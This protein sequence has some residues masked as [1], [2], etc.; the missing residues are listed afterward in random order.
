MGS[1]KKRKGEAAQRAHDAFG[2]GREMVNSHPL[3]Q[4]LAYEVRFERFVSAQQVAKDGW[5]VVTQTGCV[6]C[7]PE[8]LAS[9][10]E[11]A[12]ALATG[13]LHHA[14]G[15][16]REHEDPQLWQLACEL[17][18][19][20]FLHDL[21]FGR[22]PFGS[23]P[24]A[25]AG[26]DADALVRQLQ[27][28]PDLARSL[29]RAMPPLSGDRPG[30]IL[31]GVAKDWQGTPV[32]FAKLFALGLR[33]AVAGAVEVAGGLRKSL[34][35]PGHKRSVYERA[36]DWFVSG[37]PLLGALARH[38]EIVDDP[39]V[40]RRLD[41]SVAAVDE[42]EERIYVN[43]GAGLDF[44][45]CI[46][47]IAHELLHVG[48]RHLDRR[49]GRDAFLWNVACDFV[50][51]AWLL[52]MR[53]GSP[54]S[55]GM[56]H[57]AKLAGMSAEEV[58]DRVVKDLRLQRRL[59][60]LRGRGLGDMMEHD[61]RVPACGSWTDL[62]ALYRSYLSRGLDLHTAQGRG[63]LPAGLVEEIRALLQPPVPW[64][65]RLAH[66][67]EEWFPSIVPKRTYAR[68]SRRQAS[69]PD[70]PRPSYHIPDEM[71][72]G[73]TFGVVLDTSG[74]MNRRQLGMALGAI[75][76]Y[77]DRHDVR[78]ARVVFCD[79]HPYDA[80]YLLPE[81]IAG[82]VRVRG[83]GGTILQPGVDLL[84]AAEDFPDDGPIL[85]ITDGDCDVLRIRREHAFLLPKGRRLPFGTKA[86]V[87]EFA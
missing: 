10:E 74:S 81:Q 42:L 16:I 86:P 36:R 70:I 61:G 38:F 65:V 1:R 73:R 28:S 2:R 52:E 3:F 34:G 5:I 84:E 11:W 69:T 48:L 49:Q 45:Q 32:D 60:T 33:S 43:R 87:F 76:S 44:D 26:R 35:S 85:L 55:I 19:A 77:A 47:V 80:G 40:C 79:A 22:S 58:Y 9:A 18:A 4:P 39:E 83:R 13:L 37:Y 66:W 71:R 54:P 78:A 17:A 67:F 59:A 51:N 68:P 53:V 24:S 12:F 14:L 15:H 20:R 25:P 50:I 29:G 8:R 46:F 56:L 41:V 75:A 27:A 31:D 7:H 57:D 6:W 82:R 63:L 64:D 72:E 30:M 23:P 62:D 21:A